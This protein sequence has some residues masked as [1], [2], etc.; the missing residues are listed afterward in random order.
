M[1]VADDYETAFDCKS[2]SVVFI[3]TPLSLCI[4]DCL[5]RGNTYLLNN[6]ETQQCV[7][8]WAQELHESNPQRQS[9]QAH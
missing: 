1:V 8:T 3:K 7:S 5:I 2:Q 9:T 4:T 6:N